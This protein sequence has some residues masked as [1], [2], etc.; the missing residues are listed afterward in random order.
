MLVWPF[1]RRPLIIC[2]NA[3]DS[4]EVSL[5][6]TS[7]RETP[8]AC[9]TLTEKFTRTYPILR[10]QEYYRESRRRQASSFTGRLQVCED[11]SSTRLIRRVKTLEPGRPNRVGA[12][13]SW[14]FAK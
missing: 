8:S 5:P 1:F 11:D 13:R 14:K 9:R 3:L 2:W 10:V 4:N 7:T 12:E 6:F